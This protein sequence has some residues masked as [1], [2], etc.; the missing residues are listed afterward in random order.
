LGVATQPGRHAIENGRDPIAS[1]LDDRREAAPIVLES[2]I[3]LRRYRW[4][5]APSDIV[6]GTNAIELSGAHPGDQL[7][8]PPDW[9]RVSRGD[10]GEETGVASEGIR[11]TLLFGRL[12]DEGIKV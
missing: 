11:L 3:E 8:H 1:P 9:K 4:F 12:T 2:C 5:L 10:F 7:P 6:P